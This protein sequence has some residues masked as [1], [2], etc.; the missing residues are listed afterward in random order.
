MPAPVFVRVCKGE[1][2]VEYEMA[3]IVLRS[4]RRGNGLGGA[5]RETKN[6]R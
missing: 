6:K 4:E 5:K 2:H 3:F 1:R